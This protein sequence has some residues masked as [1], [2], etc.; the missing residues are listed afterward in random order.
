MI[1]RFDLLAAPLLGAIAT[2][3]FAPVSFWPAPV[4]ALAGLF[5]LCAERGWR[6]ATLLGW[7]FGV[8]HFGAGVYWVFISTHVYGGAPFWL[9]IALAGTLFAYLALYPAL[10]CGLASRLGAWR[11]A[12]GW[13]LL[14][15]LW[16]LAELLRGWVYSG[17]PWL[18]L[19]YVALDMPAQRFA[20]LIGVHGISLLL[21]LS[22]Y[23]LYRSFG[24]RGAQRPLALMVALLPLAGALLPPPAQWTRNAAPPLHVAIVQ[25]NVPQDEKW[26]GGRSEEILARYRAMTLAA[27]ADLIAWP[28]VVPDRPLDQ[29]GEYFSELDA[30]LRERDSALLAGVLIR[31]EGPTIYNSIVALGGAQGRYDKRHLVPFGEYF[32]IPDWLRPIMDVLGTPYSDFSAGGPAYA[33]VRV[34]GQELGI[35]ICFEDVFGAEFARESRAASVLVNATNDAWFA[36]SSAPHQHLAIARFRALENGRWLVRATN[37]GISALI[38]PDGRVES[39]SQQYATEL[40]RGQVWP[41]QGL[42]PYARWRD[43]PLWVLAIASLLAGF[44]IHF[45]NRA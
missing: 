19:G 30:Q 3:G 28:E 44:V 21:A 16:L 34:N 27:D 24:A 31:G 2:L 4:V 26:E 6:R 40:M 9:G 33:P 45:R 8:A 11:G 32:P 17:F 13:L 12:I 35:S 20:P 7:L 23:A 39:R 25:G 10:V 22:A 1:P 41:R 37:T 36:H 42:T 29:L 18:S 38:G 5:A 14:P 43:A 15:G